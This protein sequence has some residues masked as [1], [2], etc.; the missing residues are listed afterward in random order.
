VKTCALN[1]NNRSGMKFLWV[2]YGNEKYGVLTAIRNMLRGLAGRGFDVRIVSLTNGSAT[3]SLRQD[4]FDVDTLLLKAK[5]G[6]Q[7]RGFG[8]LISLFNSL[9]SLPISTIAICRYIKKLAPDVVHA[10]SPGIIPLCALACSL[11]KT[12]FVWEIANAIGDGYIFSANKRIYRFLCRISK[13]QV[14]ANSQY[15][16]NTLRSKKVIPK[17]FY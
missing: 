3:E 7:G 12:R 5:D 9:L 17:V 2:V 10:T 6:A 14:L 8:K 13:C 11:A 15:T 16:A 4:G 1:S